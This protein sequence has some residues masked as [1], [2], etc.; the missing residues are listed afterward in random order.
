MDAEIGNALSAMIR[1]GRISVKNAHKV[2]EQFT[3]IP[4]RC[5]TIRLQEALAFVLDC[6]RQFRTPILSLDKKMI[7]LAQQLQVTTLEVSL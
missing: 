1:R 3:R 5:I 4:I 2:I 6:A 7:E